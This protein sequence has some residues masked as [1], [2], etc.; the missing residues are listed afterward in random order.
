MIQEHN[1]NGIRRRGFLRKSVLAGT[2]ICLTPILEKATA[3]ERGI[4]GKSAAASKTSNEAGMA[5]SAHWVTAVRH[6][7]YRRWGSAA[8]D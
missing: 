1:H 3:S 8:W 5:V 4:S 6:S 7:V 2:A